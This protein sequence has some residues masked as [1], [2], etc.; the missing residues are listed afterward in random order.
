MPMQSTTELIDSRRFLG[1]EFLMW[2][3]YKTECFDGLLEIQ[4]HGQVE[5]IFDDRLTLESYLAE[6]ERNMFRGGAPAHSREAKIALREGKRP[7]RA[8]LRFV[9]EGR[10]WK[11]KFKAE[12]FAIST[13]KIPALMTDRDD[14]KFFERMSLVDEVEEL[15][16]RLYTEFVVIRSSNGWEQ[17]M[18]PAL[19]D[20]IYADDPVGRDHYP[21][22][23]LD[24]VYNDA[25]DDG[26]TPGATE[27][28]AAQ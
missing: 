19:R 5:V 14:E 21:S 13:L 15:I 17:E 18:L 27:S 28:D 25:F 22:D 1:P 8:R 6:T 20:W 26:I 16:E 4:K 12:D 3:W 24:R 11:F 10:E 23:I 7:T 2:L 9:K